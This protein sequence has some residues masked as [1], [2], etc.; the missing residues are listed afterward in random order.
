MRMELREVE[1]KSGKTGVEDEGGSCCTV[2]DLDERKLV[3]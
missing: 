3:V 1:I 2:K